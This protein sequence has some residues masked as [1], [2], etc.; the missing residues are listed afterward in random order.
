MLHLKNLEPTYYPSNKSDLPG[1]NLRA[2]R[3]STRSAS[4]GCS[5]RKSANEEKPGRDEKVKKQYRQGKERHGTR[6]IPAGNEPT[7][8]STI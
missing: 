3:S 6:A 5:M 8:N 7:K 1:P 2:S 4:V